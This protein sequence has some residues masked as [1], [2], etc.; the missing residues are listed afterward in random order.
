MVC[1]FCQGYGTVADPDAC[2]ETWFAVPEM[3]CPVCVGTA[4]LSNIP[5][6]GQG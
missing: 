6:W 1:P 2:A 4:D 3:P 5:L